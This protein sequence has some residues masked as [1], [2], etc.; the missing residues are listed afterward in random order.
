MTPDRQIGDLFVTSDSTL[1]TL[2]YGRDDT[3]FHVILYW[4][5]GFNDIQH[6][7]M[8]PNSLDGLFPRTAP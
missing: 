7:R 4:N 1:A 2:I 6:L 5:D 8:H 3:H